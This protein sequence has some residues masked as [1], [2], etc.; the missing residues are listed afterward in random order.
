MIFSRLG[1]NIQKTF[2]PHPVA[3]EQ[4]KKPD[5]D[6][7][8]VFFI[9]SKP[10]DPFVKGK[11]ED[12]FKLL[13][14]PYD[15]RFE[16]YYLPATLENSDYPNLIPAGQLVDTI[17]APTLLT[18][19]NWRENTDRYRRVSRF[20]EYLFSRIDKLQAPGFDPKWKDVN[21]NARVPG[22]ARFKPAQDWINT[23]STAAGLRR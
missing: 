5:S 9:T 15:T 8:G 19:Y 11:W 1:I 17:A 13:S 22:L 18:A 21:L 6:M 16:D 12:G 7:A 3:M 20:V 14:V 23:N 10:V 2:I 4:M